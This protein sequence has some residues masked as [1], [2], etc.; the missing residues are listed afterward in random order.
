[1]AYWLRLEDKDGRC[2]EFQR[3]RILETTKCIC[4][5]ILRPVVSTVYFRDISDPTVPGRGAG[6]HVLESM[7]I[8]SLAK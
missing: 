2:T 7:F 3:L 6:E 1:M 5:G 8:V 4:A